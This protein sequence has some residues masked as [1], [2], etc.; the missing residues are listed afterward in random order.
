MIALGRL[1]RLALA[2]G[3]PFVCAVTLMSSMSMAQGT[4]PGVEPARVLPAAELF[5]WA[6]VN[7][8]PEFHDSH[9]DFISSGLVQDSTTG[10]FHHPEWNLSAG[11][12]LVDGKD[13]CTVAF[14]SDL[15][16]KVV[17][18]VFIDAFDAAGL[19]RNF[20]WGEGEL[21]GS[22]DLPGGGLFNLFSQDR[23]GKAYY[24]AVA[25]VIP[26]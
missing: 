25:A 13:A 11:V 17:R 19:P 21:I 26:R 24:I 12:G 6:C 22:G 23:N 14:S 18:R 15:D 1:T 9:E 2:T 4:G 16:F 7:Q 20:D 3:T 10:V 5:L 8:L